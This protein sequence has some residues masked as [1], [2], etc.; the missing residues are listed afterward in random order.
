MACRLLATKAFLH[1]FS[2]GCGGFTDWGLGFIKGAFIVIIFTRNAMVDLGSRV[3]EGLKNYY[4]ESDVSII[5]TVCWW[6]GGASSCRSCRRGTGCRWRGVPRKTSWTRGRSSP[7]PCSSLSSLARN[8]RCARLTLKT[9]NRHR[10]GESFA[11][12]LA[13][14]QLYGDRASAAHH[15]GTEQDI[16]QLEYKMGG[17]HKPPAHWH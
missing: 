15:L 11:G 3:D 8:S 2:L 14:R 16:G 7:A 6:T 9:V 4:I 10:C 5:S 12:R 17:F 13:R 1:H